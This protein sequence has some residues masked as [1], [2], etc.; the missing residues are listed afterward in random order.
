MQEAWVGLDLVEVARFEAALGRHP[1][2]EERVFTPAE[3]SYC[4]ARGGPALHYAAR[5]AAKEA[6][7]KL[8]GSGVVS[9]QEIEVLAGVPGDGMSRGGAPKVTL[10]GRTAEIARERGI[11]DLTV[12]LSHVDSLAGACVVAVARPLGGGE[13]D[14]A[15]YLDSDRGPAA[16]CSLAERPAVFT[17]AQVRELDRATIEDV[18][19][20]GPVL[21]ERAAVGVTLLIQSRYPD[22]HTLI[23]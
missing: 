19:V 2:L 21:M 12:S 8:L 10:S 16:L 23:V 13:M 20:P 18:G 1:R 14:V 9:W 5:F 17:P 22:R 7:G 6:V 3:I 15:S 11:G 4:R